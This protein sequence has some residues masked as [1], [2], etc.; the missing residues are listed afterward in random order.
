ML[1][2]LEY[3]A[4]VLA[5]VFIGAIIYLLIIMVC[6]YYMNPLR[7]FRKKGPKVFRRRS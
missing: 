2:A 3:T 4:I 6:S 1:E 7:V 5:P